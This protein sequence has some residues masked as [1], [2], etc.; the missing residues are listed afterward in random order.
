MT[1]DVRTLLHDTAEAPSRAPDLGA[2]MQRARAR[3]RRHRGFGALAAVVVAALVVGALGFGSGGGDGAQVA[4]GPR[5]TNSEVPEGWKQIQADPG[6][7]IAIPPG[8]DTYDYGHTDVADL[9]IAVGTANPE[10]EIPFG[11][12]DAAGNTGAGPDGAWVTVWE[13]PAGSTSVNGPAGNVLGVGAIVRPRSPERAP[14]MVRRA[15]A[16]AVPSPRSRS[17][18]PAASSWPASSSGNR[19]NRNPSSKRRSTP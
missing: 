12:P 3:R 8:W 1:T 17:R 13:Y 9:R 5:Q 19:S 7:T 16:T 6:I 10:V 4:I 2:A 14:S 18:T 15:P 11:C